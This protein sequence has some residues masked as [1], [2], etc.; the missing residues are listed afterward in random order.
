MAVSEE[1]EEGFFPRIESLPAPE[2][3]APALPL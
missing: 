1:V 3:T 2:A